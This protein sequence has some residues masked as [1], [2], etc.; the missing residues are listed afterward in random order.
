[1]NGYPDLPKNLAGIVPT[2]ELLN[3]MPREL[4]QEFRAFIFD[5]NPK[6]KIGAVNP[7]NKV[8]QNYAKEKFGDNV[9]WFCAT[10]EDVSFILKNYSHDFQ[11]VQN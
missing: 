3:L 1:M 7:D 9:A 8:L 11:K 2:K 5:K 10:N 6:I 4:V